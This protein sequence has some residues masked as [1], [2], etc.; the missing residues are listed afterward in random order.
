MFA[1]LIP[2]LDYHM[3]SSTGNYTKGLSIETIAWTN[4]TITIPL[5]FNFW[6]SKKTAPQEALRDRLFISILCF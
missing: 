3:D 1:K 5:G 2:G 6:F 4:G